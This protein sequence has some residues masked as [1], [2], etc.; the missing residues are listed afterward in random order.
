MRNIFILLIVFLLAACSAWGSN[1]L[2]NYKDVQFFNIREL[3]AVPRVSLE[4]SGLAMHSS[5][6][7]E[8]IDTKIEDGCMTV[9]VHLVPAREGLRG[10]FSY[11]IDVPETINSVCFGSAKSLIWKRGIG[12]VKTA[13]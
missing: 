6:A 8:R 2:L 3:R 4:L 1:M 12:P 7:V 9:F 10:D 5:L 11:N 13:P